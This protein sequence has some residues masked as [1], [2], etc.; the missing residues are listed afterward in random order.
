MKTCP[1]EFIR[2]ELEVRN[3]T[4]GTLARVMG[5]PVAVINQII[6]GKKRI[7]TK[8]AT[9]L[10]AAFGTSAEFWMNLEKNYRL[11]KLKKGER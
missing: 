9:E 11:Y 5:R 6:K 7:T 3:W 1:G 8:T 10:S 4:Q 2:D